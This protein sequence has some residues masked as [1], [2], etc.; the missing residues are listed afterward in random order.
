MSSFRLLSIILDGCYLCINQVFACQA[1]AGTISQLSQLNDSGSES[2]GEEEESVE[3]VQDYSSKASTRQ[4]YEDLDVIQ[5]TSSQTVTKAR[6]AADEKPQPISRPIAA[7]HRAE[8]DSDS[9]SDSDD[10][11]GQ[12]NYNAYGGGDSIAEVI[13]S[14]DEDIDERY[15]YDEPGLDTSEEANQATISRPSTSSGIRSTVAVDLSAVSA[16]LEQNHAVSNGKEKE[17]ED[18][19]TAEQELIDSTVKLLRLLANLSI[20]ESIGLY[21]SRR[22]EPFQVLA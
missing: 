18:D 22:C 16:R 3:N 20:D 19:D 12:Y 13:I 7:S 21:L 14:D 15:G 10:N 5:T 11:N 8:N 6:A 4:E 9:D 17:Q 2:G 1:C